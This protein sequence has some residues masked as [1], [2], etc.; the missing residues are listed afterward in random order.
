M[1]TIPFNKPAFLPESR[2][3]MLHVLESGNIKGR[4]PY[5][6]KVED[7]LELT[8]PEISKVLLTTSCTH[9]LETAAILLN[10]KEGDEV[11][12]P[13]FTFVSSALAFYM[14]GASI[15]FCDVRS[16]TLNIDENLLEDHINENTKAIVVVHYAGVSCEMD[17]IMAIA[18]KNNLVVIEDNAHGIFGKYKGNDLGTFG[19]F[20]TYS[21]HETKNISC[22]EGGALFI[23]DEAMIE[24]AEI[25]LE[26]GTNRS[27][28]IRG[29]VDKYSWSDKGSSYV[30]SDILASLLYTQLIFS[31]SIQE[32]RQLLWENYFNNLDSWAKENNIRLPIVPDYCNQSY[33]MFYMIFPSQKSRNAFIDHLANY[34]INATFHYLPLDR[35]LMGTKIAID[36]QLACPISD[37]LSKQI[38]RLPL[39]FDLSSQEQARVIK[40]TFDYKI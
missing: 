6:K 38:V 8:H 32:K 18:E 22:G 5:T 7:L 21:F 33:H 16:D 17:T 3:T 34:S 26:K 39:F 9:A 13:A 14:H 31:E 15:R 12:V 11:I 10:L 27:L 35:S 29:Q 25:I 36:D 2:E 30:L 40:A 23:R 19:D 37:D 1:K 4:G 20:S 28:F 24:R